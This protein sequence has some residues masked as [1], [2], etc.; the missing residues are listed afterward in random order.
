VRDERTVAVAGSPTVERGNVTAKSRD[1]V[2]G[3]FLPKSHAALA[4]LRRRLT[5]PSAIHWFGGSG[6]VSANGTTITGN[7]DVCLGCT[8]TFNS[9]K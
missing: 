5:R 4:D 2:L 1:G 7:S 8:F 6:A 9:S 3:I